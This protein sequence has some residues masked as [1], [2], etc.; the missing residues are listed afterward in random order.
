MQ[1]NSR[2]GRVTARIPD[3][4]PKGMGIGG[5]LTSD[6][7]GLR[8]TLDPETLGKLD[9]K[10][11]LASKEQLTNAEKT[12]LEQLNEV[13]G[14]ID[15]T[16]SIRDPLYKQFVEAMSASGEYRELRKPILTD[17]ERDKQKQIAKEILRDIKEQQS[18]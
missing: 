13:L 16:Q 12:E 7:F 15:F 11:E 18:E 3:G 9:R 6:L 4:D 17:D 1:R 5:I 14:N 2:S 10:R 8:S